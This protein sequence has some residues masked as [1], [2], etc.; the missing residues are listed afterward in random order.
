MKLI[1]IVG[2]SAVG[3][4]TVGF[5]LAERTGYRFFHN[6]MVIE[7]LNSLFGFHDSR[8]W[9]LVGEF[10]RRIFEELSG[11]PVA[12]VI[13]T[14]V[15]ALDQ[16]SDHQELLSYL[17]CLGVKLQD[18]LFVELE[19]DQA[20]RMERNKSPLRLQEKKSKNN[21]AES[22]KFIY[23]SEQRYQLNSAG[24]FLYP[25]NHLKIN[26]TQREP[27]VVASLILEEIEKKFGPQAE[28]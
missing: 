26:N 3:K 13:F 16:E 17:G 22:E 5:E 15:W 25:D 1:V 7:P 2:P 21:L 11:C 14:Y 10:R 23:D 28:K 9:K 4:M 24:D 20:T 18:V 19:A 12:G 27:Q 8:M 6:H